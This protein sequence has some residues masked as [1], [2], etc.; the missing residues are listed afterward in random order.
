M[1]AR[2]QEVTHI[3]YEFTTG[4]GRAERRPFHVDWLLGIAA[5][6]ERP[7]N[8]IVRGGIDALPQTRR[9]L[10]KGERS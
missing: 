10:Q 6:A 4:T 8:L 7:L 9:R 2:G 5:T 3:A 1:S